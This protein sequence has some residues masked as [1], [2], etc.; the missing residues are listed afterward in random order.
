MRCVAFGQRGVVAF[1]LPQEGT[2]EAV[3]VDS[4]WR[5]ARGIA[6]RVA[7]TV[8]V[9]LEVRAF[10]QLSRRYPRE[11]WRYI[12]FFVLSPASFWTR[13]FTAHALPVFGAI[14]LVS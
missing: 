13:G 7:Y 11:S 5:A 4:M 3:V 1:S 14:Y 12:I 8:D 9:W 6:Y 2:A 10:R